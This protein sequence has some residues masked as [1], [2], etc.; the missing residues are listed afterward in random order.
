MLGR[1]LGWHDDAVAAQA[2]RLSSDPDAVADAIL[3][4]SRV[5]VQ[6]SVRALDALAPDVNLTGFRVLTLLDQQGPLRLIDVAAAL[7]VT[8]T[9]ATRLADRLVEHGLVERV[10][11][12]DDRREVHLAIAASGQSLVRGVSSRR[13]RFV[14][15]VLRDFSA[16]DQAVVVRLLGRIAEVTANVEMETA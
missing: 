1:S 16:P 14:V 5:L 15:S 11:Q 12:S 8:S 10:R 6:V 2:P 4:A 7:D 13:G 9:T 3:M